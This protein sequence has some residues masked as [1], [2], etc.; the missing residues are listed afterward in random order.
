MA[1]DIT[2]LHF[3]SSLYANCVIRCQEH[4]LIECNIY[5]NIYT[6]IR[7]VSSTKTALHVIKCDHDLML[8]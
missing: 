3:E 8:S 7:F 1:I 2:K 5:I 4:E 6:Y